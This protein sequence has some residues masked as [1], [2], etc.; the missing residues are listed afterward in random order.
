MIKKILVADDDQGILTS[1][2]FLFKSQP[3]DVTFAHTPQEVLFF[4]KKE[5][6][7]LV[8]MDLNYE[9]DTTSG[10]EGLTLIKAIK[11][12][13]D[14]LPIVVMTG[15]ASIEI[16]VVAMQLG[17][18][19]F[20]QKPWDNERLI[21]ILN[22]QLLLAA[23]SRQSNRLSA[24]NQLL[25]SELGRNEALK[26][27]AHSAPMKQL[28]CQLEQF[29]VTDINILLT[30]ENGTGKSM[31]VNFIHQLSLRAKQ[32]LV[33][34]N[35]GSIPE[36]LFESEMFGH[37]KGAF[38]D[39]KENRIGRFELADQ[40]TL[41]L[42]EIANVP[43]TQQAK[44]LRVLEE[45]QFERVG[46]S[47]TQQTNFRLISATNGDL[48]ALVESGE[49]RQDL[50]F[51]LNTLVLHVPALRERQEDI[52]LLTQDFIEQTAKRYHKAKPTLSAEALQQLQQYR[53]PGNVR[54]LSHTIERAVL[55]ATES[56][57]VEHLML[58]NSASDTNQACDNIDA[59]FTDK[60]LVE[61][62]R[63]VISSR[64]NAFSGCASSAAKSLD[65]SRSAF[66]RR[67]DKLGL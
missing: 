45:K 2:R 21:S 36:T 29:S 63:K 64:L 48:Q 54:E 41:F 28:M 59:S 26:P 65:L 52:V 43:L 5:R 49:F 61:I 62:E 56:I 11:K 33:S 17:A 55:L 9:Q 16:A 24:E 57:E 7:D 25:K 37:I 6:F 14:E 15:W 1:L 47:Q 18:S 44:L 39:A 22:Q 35:M 50:M 40:G 58:T 46:S 38:T 20:V 10:D 51:R 4:V 13:D 67:L 66:Y 19:D 32:P 23:K 31:L 12:L 34:V 27:I 30:G 60:T 8:L 3:Y 42:D 53:W